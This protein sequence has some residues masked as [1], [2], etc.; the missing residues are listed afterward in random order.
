VAYSNARSSGVEASLSRRRRPWFVGLQ[1]SSCVQAAHTARLA[2][3][4]EERQRA[5]R[6][7]GDGSRIP[8]L[9]GLSQRRLKHLPAVIFSAG[10]RRRIGAL[11]PH[12]SPLFPSVR[13][14]LSVL[15]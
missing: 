2:H 7:P 11:T 13:D 3:A 10:K 6:R 12:T 8:Q 4:V 9:L 5:A 1:S 14:R 15:A